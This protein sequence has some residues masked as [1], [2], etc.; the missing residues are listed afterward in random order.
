MSE[1]DL[2]KALASTIETSD[3]GTKALGVF[4]QDQ[5]S[6]VLTL[7]FLQE[8][9]SVTLASDVAIDDRVINLVGGHGTLVGEVIELAVTGTNQFMQAEVLAVN[10]NAVTLDQPANVIYTVAGSIVLRSTPQMLVDGSVTPQVFSIVPLPGQ[11]GDMVRIIIALEGSDGMDFSTFGSE[12]PLINGCV[13]RVKNSDGTFKNLFNFKANAGLIGQG[14][15]YA[16]LQN[17]GNNLR[18]FASRITWGGQSKH[19][20][21]IRLD[22]SIGEELQIVIQDDLTSGSNVEFRVQAQGHEVQ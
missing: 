16:F 12:N 20:V 11:V 2:L 17:I 9:A 1:R 10:V 19:G 6:P 22:G 15:D 4:V 3:R 14:F 5:T 13:V 8:R 7:P 18:G 21:V